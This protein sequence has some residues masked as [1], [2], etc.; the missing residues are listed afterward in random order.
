MHREEYHILRAM[1]IRMRLLS[2]AYHLHRS[3]LLGQ[4]YYIHI[5]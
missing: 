2:G 3:Q 1:M 4:V 5:N